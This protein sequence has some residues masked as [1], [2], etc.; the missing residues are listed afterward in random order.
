MAN[1]DDEELREIEEKV[2]AV[3]HHSRSMPP[4]DPLRDALND[5]VTFI[6]SIIERE[7]GNAQLRLR[8]ILPELGMGVTTLQRRFKKKY[9]KNI[10]RLMTDVRLESAGHKLVYLSTERIGAVA[11]L[12]G[13]AEIRD[14]NYFFSGHTGL[15]PTEWRRRELERI[16]K[17]NTEREQENGEP[18]D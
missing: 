18:N 6:H 1:R 9:K 3:I 8:M 4:G 11:K 12:L 16:A 13:Y 15:P 5:P 2:I 14:F 10:K 7:Y 17:E